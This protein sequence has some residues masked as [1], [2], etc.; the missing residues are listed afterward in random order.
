MMSTSESKRERVHV[1]VHGRV[2]GVGFRAFT[3]SAAARHGLTGWVRNRIQGTVETVAEG[4]RPQLE[5]FLRDLR[6]GPGPSHVDDLQIEWLA[7]T[8]EFSDFQ[9]RWTV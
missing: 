6:T 8:G 7:A 4:T 5:A 9:V 2:Q 1:A 3:A